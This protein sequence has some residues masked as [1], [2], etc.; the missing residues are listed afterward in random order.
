[1]G[2]GSGIW[3]RDPGSGKNLF[4]TRI[5]DSGVKKAPDPGSGYATLLKGTVQRDGSDRN[6][7]PSIG[8]H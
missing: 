1:M 2:L 7:A 8:L 6:Q 4:R 3:I 5:P